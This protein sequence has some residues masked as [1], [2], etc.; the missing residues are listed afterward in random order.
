MPDPVTGTIAAVGTIGGA[1]IN[2]NAASK[3]AD[4]QVNASNAASQLQWQQYQQNR[5]DMMPWMQRG[6]SA[7]NQLAYLLG[8]PGYGPVSGAPGTGVERWV[9]RPEGGANYGS[10]NPSDRY[11]ITDGEWGLNRPGDGSGN[12]SYGQ[13]GATSDGMGGFSYNPAQGGYG[14]LMKDFGMEDFN[15]DPGYAF[16]MAEGHKA[17]ERSAAARGS[18]LSGGQLK[19]LTRYGQDMGSQEY[20][21]AYNRYMNNRASKFN[22]LSS[23]AGLGQTSAGQVANMGTQVAGMVGNNMMDAGQA[24]AGGTSAAAGAWGNALSAGTNLWTDWQMRKRR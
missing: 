16:R 7:G 22:Q 6:N 23:V 5:Q 17:L 4:A 10:K 18:L 3:A 12:P 8:L 24:R 19:A 9:N 1:L 11:E 13:G 2:S 15:A 20:G 14:S 21:N